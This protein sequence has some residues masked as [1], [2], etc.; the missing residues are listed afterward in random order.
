M[1]LLLRFF[2]YSW[3]LLPGIALCQN[4]T[5]SGQ[6]LDNHH[7]P[8]PFTTLYV[9]NSGKGAVA[10]I[11]GRFK[12]SLNITDLEKGI[13]FSCLGFD[14]SLYTGNLLRNNIP[15]Q[16]ILKSKEQTLQEITIHPS[17]NPAHR[18]IQMAYTNRNLNDPEQL[19]S[20]SYI[21][22]NK[23][24]I[25]GLPAGNSNP[26]QGE[27]FA[28]DTALVPLYDKQ[29][30]FITESVSERSFQFPDKTYERVL[31]SK[32]SGLKTPFF[33]V[34]SN[35]L[36]SFSFYEEEV[37]LFDVPYLNPISKN[38]TRFY[39]FQLEDTLLQGQDSV[40]IISFKP[41]PKKTFNALKGVIYIHSGSYAV[42]NVI[43]EPVYPERNIRVK[44][45]QQYSFIHQSHWFPT[46]LHTEWIYTDTITDTQNKGGHSTQDPFFMKAVHKTY[47]QQIRINPK[48]DP[49][50]FSEVTVNMNVDSIEKSSGFMHLYRY[51]SL[52]RKEKYSYSVIDSLGEKLKLDE[53]S[54]LLKALVSKKINF[55]RIN[56]HLDDFLSYNDYEHL[57]LA[58]HL[59]TSD[60]LFRFGSLGAYIAYGFKDKAMKYGSDFTFFLWKKKELQWKTLY[61]KDIQEMAATRF[62]ENNLS[63]NN[64]ERFRDYYVRWMSLEEK[65]QTQLSF[66]CFKY[67]KCNF[68]LRLRQFSNINPLQPTFDN[69]HYSQQS[70]LNLAETGM[71]LKF[72]YK[73][74]FTQLFDTKISQGSVFP[75]LYLNVYRSIPTPLHS[76]SYGIDYV[77]TDFKIEQ[78]LP[79]SNS[80]YISW[81]I[82]SG[83]VWGKLPY[84]LLYNNKGSAGSVFS[85]SAQNS[86][87]TMNMN[88]FVSTVYAACFVNLNL[89]RLFIPAQYFNPSVVLVHNMGIGQY[90]YSGIPSGA[91]IFRSIEK[92]YFESGFRIN[93]V[94][95]SGLSGIGIAA[96]YRYGPY[97]L[98]HFKENLAIKL[99]LSFNL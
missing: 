61:R 40:F 67:L 53:K 84:T 97:Q 12:L 27:S 24:Y 70:T 33:S 95:V 78:Q 68:L 26:N 93:N 66:R 9:V 6:V 34:L 63:L 41:R 88:E 3:A 80:R 28:T 83:K 49:G 51:D 89:G 45:Q 8:V 90:H 81:Q 47:L 65:W 23:M 46:Q 86:F 25:S 44:I 77:R 1:S 14:S 92:G 64:S 31:A 52:N 59:S 5:I 98:Q 60:K 22:Y 17:E 2:Y 15:V 21:A 43:T 75:A 39:A 62:F 4:V 54:A 48:I 7:Q 57:R 82:Q 11:D 72:I 71:E 13:L 50:I 10:D 87:E 58:L 38:S 35:N 94:L 29:Y 56:W 30:F 36:Q 85:I 16:V 73:E 99:T 96:L 69:L 79:L 76:F 32:V 91:T 20:F 42:Q 74:K 55:G 18:I 19:A 37:K